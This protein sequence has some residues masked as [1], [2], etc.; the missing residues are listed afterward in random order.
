MVQIVV[1]NAM[2]PSVYEMKIEAELDRLLILSLKVDASE[3][4]SSL[5]GICFFTSNIPKIHKTGE[6]C[7]IT[8]QSL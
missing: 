8:K 2:K 5:M 1:Y 3:S 4:Q 6:I 7:H